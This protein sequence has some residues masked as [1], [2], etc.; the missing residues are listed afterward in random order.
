MD[1]AAQGAIVKLGKQISE[2]K[3]RVLTA[4]VNILTGLAKAMRLY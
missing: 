1:A 4:Q 2:K 3:L